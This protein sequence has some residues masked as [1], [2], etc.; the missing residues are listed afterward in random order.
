MADGPWV[1]E[2]LLVIAAFA[3][4]ITK[5]VDLIESILLD[6]LKAKSFVPPRWV[7]VN[8]YLTADGKGQARVWKL[9]HEGQTKFLPEMEVEPCLRQ[10]CK[11]LLRFIKL[12][13][14]FVIAIQLFLY[15]ALMRKS[16]IQITG[17]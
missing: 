14:K 10:I 11:E 6:V 9:V 2:E 15:M 8:G 16:T 5:E 17:S 12:F 3:G 7:N 1:F 13:I 4:S